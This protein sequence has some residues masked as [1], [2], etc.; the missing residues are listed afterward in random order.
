MLAHLRLPLPSPPT[1]T[2]VSTQQGAAK[3]CH[4]ASIFFS[5]HLLS[6][7]RL[8]MCGHVYVC[9]SVLSLLRPTLIGPSLL[10]A[11][12]R[13]YVG[14][15]SLVSSR[16]F[17]SPLSPS[18]ASLFVLFL[19]M[20]FCTYTHTR[21]CTHHPLYLHHRA[22]VSRSILVCVCV[23]LFPFFSLCISVKL[24]RSFSP[25]P[26][27]DAPKQNEAMWRHCAVRRSSS[28]SGRARER[29]RCCW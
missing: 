11:H 27:Q 1:C 12:L 13:T 6:L 21:T 24:I 15:S 19:C 4:K 9:V 8:V 28:H 22:C 5:R 14:A 17:F 23:C 26:S 7:F 29:P 2:P 20:S 10:L 18:P 3:V 25:H 16:I